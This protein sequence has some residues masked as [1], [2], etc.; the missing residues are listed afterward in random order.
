MRQESHTNVRI[1]NVYCASLGS[2]FAMERMAHDFFSLL[3]PGFPNNGFDLSNAFV[4]QSARFGSLQIAR[5]FAFAGQA[6]VGTTRFA[7]DEKR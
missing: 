7:R 5:Q 6:Y 2:K 4:T 1:P 3:K